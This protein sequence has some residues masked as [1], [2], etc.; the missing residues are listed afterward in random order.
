MLNHL[1]NVELYHEEVRR[2][3]EA[4]LDWLHEHACSRTYG[5]G[6]LFFKILFF[7]LAIVKVIQRLFSRIF[8][9]S[10]VLSCGHDFKLAV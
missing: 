3:F 5:L 6:K 8:D 7:F 10:Y 1:P 9:S 4:T 2:N